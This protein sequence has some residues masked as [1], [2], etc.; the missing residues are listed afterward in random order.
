MTLTGSANC[1]QLLNGTINGLSLPLLERQIVGLRVSTALAL[2]ASAN[3]E[4][5]NGL[6]NQRI[7]IDVV[8]QAQAE[9]QGGGRSTAFGDPSTGTWAYAGGSFID[10]FNS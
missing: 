10:D 2:Q 5:F 4:L 6:I 7:G 1:G 9:M 8:Q 3:L